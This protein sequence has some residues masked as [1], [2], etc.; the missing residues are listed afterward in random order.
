MIAPAT[1]RHTEATRQVILD[2]AIA[3]F[4]ERRSD[5]FS[6]QDVADRA[7]LTH[8]TVY[9]Y[10]STR[11]ALMTTAARHLA[12]DLAG[13]PFSEVSTVE[14]WIDALEPHLTRTEAN[15]EIVRRILGATL[16][17]DDPWLFGQD[18]HNRDNRLWEAFR[19]Q[20]PHLLE[21]DARR[22]FAALRHLMSSASYVLLRLR[23]GLSPAEATET[24]RS[25][26]SQFVEQAARRDRAAEDGRG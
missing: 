9:R 15:F 5:D 2:A 24:I 22:T 23:F 4:L 13:E 3:L 12:R 10:F 17:S 14:E 25:S 8:R 7:G 21:G 16:A 18:I 11:Q 6:M 20:F 26:A 19:R 1:T